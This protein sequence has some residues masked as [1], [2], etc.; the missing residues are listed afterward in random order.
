MTNI[1]NTS[2]SEKFAPYSYM[3]DIPLFYY[4]SSFLLC[5]LSS[6]C[7]IHAPR[8]SEALILQLFA[9]GRCE[10]GQLL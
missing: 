10:L 4:Y 7:S 8:Q 3:L 5:I 1:K 9:N 2:N 6:C